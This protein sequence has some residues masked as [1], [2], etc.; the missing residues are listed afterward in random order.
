MPAYFE[1][2]LSQITTRWRIFHEESVFLNPR[3]ERSDFEEL[4]G[5]KDSR[6]YRHGEGVL[7][8]S[9]DDR[10]LQ[11]KLRDLLGIPR[12]PR[13]VSYWWGREAPSHLPRAKTGSA[14]LF[15]DEML[16]PVAEAIK[17]RKNRILTPEQ[18]IARQE[19]MRLFRRA[20]LE[21]YKI[22]GK[23]A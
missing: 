3:D 12:E 7:A 5:A 17:A 16:N 13:P 11:F 1:K 15:A 21:R 22:Q 4:R 19:R 10:R 2:P 9:S 8:V 23:T 20:Q 6:I 18:I 14:L